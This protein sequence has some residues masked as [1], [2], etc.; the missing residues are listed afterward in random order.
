MNRLLLACLALLFTCS[1]L[2]DDAKLAA[3][4]PPGEG[5]QVAAEGLAFPDALSADDVGNVYFCDMRSKPPVIWKLSQEGEK[6]KVA[7]ASRSGTRVGPDGRLYA[8]GNGKVVAYDLPSG[9]EEVIVG[10]NVQPN[11]LTV[12][13]KGYVYFTETAKHQVTF[14]NPKTKE[15]KATD[16]GIDKPNGIAAGPDGVTLLVSDYG[17]FNVWRFKIQPDGSLTDKHPAGTM[18]PS[19]KKPSVSGGDG[20]TVDT[21]GHAY[22]CTYA[23]LQIFDRDGQ[24]LGILPKP[25]DKGLINACFGGKDLSYLYV[26]CGDKVYRRKTLTKGALSFQ[27]AVDAPR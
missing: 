17:G 15:L 7:E 11:D 16:V 2:A 4:F 13:P 6:S 14:L 23:G 27:P 21:A 8:C 24:L 26:A 25:Q 19:E 1:L 5:W 10:E 22:V 20:M 9:K 12:T 18:K 3:I